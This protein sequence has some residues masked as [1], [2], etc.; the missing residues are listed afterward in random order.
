MSTIQPRLHYIGFDGERAVT[1]RE[2]QAQIDAIKDLR[3]ALVDQSEPFAWRDI[4]DPAEPRTLFQHIL[5]DRR[6]RIDQKRLMANR[7]PIAVATEHDGAI[8]RLEYYEGHDQLECTHDLRSADLAGK[9]LPRWM[10]QDPQAY[11][12]VA[13]M[14]QAFGVDPQLTKAV[15]QATHDPD[16]PGLADSYRREE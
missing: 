1:S 7:P 9:E 13:F 3:C 15:L 6:L 4:D 8:V 2:T 12:P 16:T 10:E 14:E 11:D 5:G